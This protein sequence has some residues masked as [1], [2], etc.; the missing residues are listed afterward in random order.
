MKKNIFYYIGFL[1]IITQNRKSAKNIKNVVMSSNVHPMIIVTFWE[2][3]ELCRTLYFIWTSCLENM[4]IYYLQWRAVQT[5]L[6]FIRLAF[7]V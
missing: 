5:K 1:H 2:V 6:S 7:S 3:S 4:F